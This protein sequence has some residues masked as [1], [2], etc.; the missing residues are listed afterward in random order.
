MPRGDALD[1]LFKD[2]TQDFVERCNPSEG[3]LDYGKEPLAIVA[4]EAPA[5]QTHS[6][7]TFG[8]AWALVA[9]SKLLELL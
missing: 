8:S 3:T 6:E 9:A 2:L 1:L 7:V 4:L 5:T